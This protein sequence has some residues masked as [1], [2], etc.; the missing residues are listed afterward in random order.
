VK[1]TVLSDQTSLRK[2]N[3]FSLQTEI[4]VIAIDVAVVVAV[5]VVDEDILLL[6]L[7]L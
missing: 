4:H 1:H 3:A 6:T 5:V 7:L 2:K